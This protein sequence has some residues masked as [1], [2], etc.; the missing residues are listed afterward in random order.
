MTETQRN[1]WC[2]SSPVSAE[3]NQA[4]Q[5][6]TSVTFATSEQH[7]DL[8]TARQKKDSA[9]VNKLIKFLQDKNPFDKESSLRN[10]VTGVI[11]AEK[12]N[13]TQAKEVGDSILDGMFGKKVCNYTFR[14]KRYSNYDGI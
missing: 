4:M 12:V 11:A 14:K 9:D 6:L 7:K 2:M 3:V 13:V 5:Q 1:V 10:V 8:S